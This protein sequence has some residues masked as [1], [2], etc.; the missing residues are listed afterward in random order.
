MSRLVI[1]IDDDGEVVYTSDGTV[2]VLIINTQV[3]RTTKDLNF[4][5]LVAGFN[6]LVP[7]WVQKEFNNFKWES[8]E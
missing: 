4:K 5:D 3:L 6:D 8:W 1:V 2:G 7:S